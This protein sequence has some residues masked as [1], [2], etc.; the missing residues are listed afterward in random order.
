LGR[1]WGWKV[2]LSAV[3]RHGGRSRSARTV[4]QVPQPLT[5]ALYEAPRA[6]VFMRAAELVTLGRI[7]TRRRPI[8]HSTQ[9]GRGEQLELSHNTIVPYPCHDHRPDPH[10]NMPNPEL[11]KD[12]SG[13]RFGRLFERFCDGSGRPNSA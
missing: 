8:T 13:L 2:V 11:R 1:G 5:M 10:S 6:M 9:F 7:V 12:V 3:L 4:A